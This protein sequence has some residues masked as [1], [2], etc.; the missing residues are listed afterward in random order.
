MKEV[1]KFF[2]CFPKSTSILFSIS[3]P[4]SDEE[5]YLLTEYNS[6]M[7]FKKRI[8]SPCLF[9]FVDD[10]ITIHVGTNNEKVVSLI[11]NNISFFLKDIDMDF[12]LVGVS[13]RV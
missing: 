2:D 1:E 6:I 5:E 8:L 13:N 11:E 12:S 3:E 9:V 4:L 10:S 7:L